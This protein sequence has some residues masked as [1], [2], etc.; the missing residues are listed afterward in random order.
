LKDETRHHSKGTRIAWHPAFVVAFQQE[1]ERYKDALE[2]TAEYPLTAEP[3]KI[4][5]LVIKKIKDITIDK[6][7][8][9]IFKAHNI[10]EYKS[11]RS[12]VSIHDFNKVYG[13]ACFYACLNKIPITDITLT[14]VESRQPTKLLSHLKKER[15]WTVEKKSAGIYIMSGDIIPIQIIDSRELSEAENLWLKNLDNELDAQRMQRLQIEID[16]SGKAEQIKTYLDVIARA[17]PDALQEAIKMSKSTLTLEQVFV[18]VGWTA[19]WEARGKA[20]GKA[21]NSLQI[22]R[23]MLALGDSPEKVAKATEVPLVKV[24]ALLKTTK[25]KQTA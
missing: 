2:F 14:F 1:L 25:V 7:I 4:D 11:P 18:N 9:A 17:N 24:K 22:A 3:L 19:K 21:E 8:A 15:G 16:R 10:V 5:V 13:Y 23:N 12:Y 20:E 6:N